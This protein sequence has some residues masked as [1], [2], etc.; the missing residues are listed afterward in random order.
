MIHGIIGICR[1]KPLLTDDPL[2]GLAPFLVGRIEK[3]K[4]CRDRAVVTIFRDR[5]AS[6]GAVKYCTDLR[7]RVTAVT[8]ETAAQEIDCSDEAHGG[9]GVSLARRIGDSDQA[10]PYEVLDLRD[11]ITD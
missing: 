9:S 3:I 6:P 4:D 5:P 10:V 7:E 11:T 8:V 1:G 2:A